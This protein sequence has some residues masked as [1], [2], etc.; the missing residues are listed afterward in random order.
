MRHNLYWLLDNATWLTFTSN[1][2]RSKISVISDCT[3]RSSVIYNSTDIRF[4]NPDATPG[5]YRG[6]NQSSLIRIGGAGRLSYKK[7]ADVLYQTFLGLKKLW[8]NVALHWIGNKDERKKNHGRFMD[9]LN[10]LEDSGDLTFTGPV[11]HEDILAHMKVLDIFVLSSIDEGCPNSMLE[12]M[13]THTWVW[14][15]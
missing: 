11:A 6:P 13:L 12:A 2:M 3:G 10:A 8:P 1:R 14:D 15:T 9:A 4:F 7:G 5:Q